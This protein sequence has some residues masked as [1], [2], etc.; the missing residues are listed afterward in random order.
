ML[1][2]K[3]MK[4]SFKTITFCSFARVVANGNRYVCI[5]EFLGHFEEGVKSDD[6]CTRFLTMARNVNNFLIN[7]VKDTHI[8]RE[9]N[10][11]FFSRIIT[12]ISCILDLARNRSIQQLD[13]NQGQQQLRS[14]HVIN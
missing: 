4:L 9:Q 8:L 11:R 6:F 12:L 10:A 14:S 1:I 13:F 3:R 5:V 7:L 2:L